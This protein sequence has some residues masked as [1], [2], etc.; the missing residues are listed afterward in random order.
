MPTWCVYSSHQCISY[1]KGVDMEVS[2]NIDMYEPTDIDPTCRIICEKCGNV[3]IVP[4]EKCI[5]GEQ[6]TILIINEVVKLKSK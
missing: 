1:G 3:S 2:Q 6:F 5:C 4:V